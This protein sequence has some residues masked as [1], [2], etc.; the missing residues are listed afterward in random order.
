MLKKIVFSGDW[1]RKTDSAAR[2]KPVLP[3]RKA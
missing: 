3:G 1:D 2:N